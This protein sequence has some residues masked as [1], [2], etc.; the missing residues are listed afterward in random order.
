MSELNLGRLITTPQ[1][2][3]AIHVAVAPM[4]A[5]ERM[6]AGQ[7]IGLV[8]GSQTHATT[9]TKSIGIV[10]PYLRSPVPRG[11][12]FWMF[13]YPQTVTGLRHDWSHP[14]FTESAIAGH[15]ASDSRSPAQE[16]VKTYALNLGL[17]YNEI[18]EGAADWVNGGEYL[19]KGGLL[20]GQYLNQEFW[21]HYQVLKGTV[22]E[23]KK[24][25][26]FT[27]SC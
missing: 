3:D 5:F 8:E 25:S 23:E 21:T 18:M 9:H 2:R 17:T 10:D 24:Q 15:V 22:P 27:C 14:A 1:N 13:L 12:T 11:A 26:F 20:E 19:N 16:W 6:H 4:I 7:H